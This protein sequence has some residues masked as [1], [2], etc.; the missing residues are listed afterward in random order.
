MKYF[1]IRNKK[2]GFFLKLD[3]S[4]DETYY[5]SASRY[6]NIE[7]L[8]FSVLHIYADD[9]PKDSFVHYYEI[10]EFES[11]EAGV[12]SSAYYLDLP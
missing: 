10:V 3:R 6:K 1:M 5:Y 7:D 9:Y 4:I 2:N 8:M 11:H 12:H